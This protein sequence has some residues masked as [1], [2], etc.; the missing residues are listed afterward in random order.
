MILECTLDVSFL[1]CV[2]DM[3]E[4]HYAF[5]KNGNGIKPQQELNLLLAVAFDGPRRVSWVG[6][7][8]TIHDFSLRRTF[9]PLALAYGVARRMGWDGMAGL[10]GR[11]Y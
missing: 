1:P 9:A 11:M 10:G 2:D 7:P 5:E 8:I 4:M 6:Q 3:L